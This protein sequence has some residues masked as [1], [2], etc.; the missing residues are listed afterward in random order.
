M[1]CVMV[2]PISAG[3]SNLGY[4]LGAR[5]GRTN[6][7]ADILSRRPQSPPESDDE[8]REIQQKIDALR[9]RL[10]DSAER[11]LPNTAVVAICQAYRVRPKRP[12][13]CNTVSAKY[14]EHDEDED[15]NLETHT[16]V[17]TIS[18]SP[19]AVPDEFV[20]PTLP[21]QSTVPSLQVD[22]WVEAQLENPEISK[23]MEYVRKG[24]RPR[25]LVHEADGVRILLR[26]WDKLVLKQGVL[27]RRVNDIANSGIL[28]LILPRQY[29]QQAMKALHDDMGHP[30]TE[31]TSG[32]L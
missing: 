6:I 18:D 25:N 29:R 24:E 16:L 3:M 19:D 8:D 1:L 27:Y 23:V 4:I 30:G 13:C 22:N 17:E 2:P 31:K 5:P 10:N 28:Q 15:D 14:T 7:D 12:V 9:E 20:N 11:S 21:G 26:Q 32:L